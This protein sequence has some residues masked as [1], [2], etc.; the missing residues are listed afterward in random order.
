MRYRCG[1]NAG[2]GLLAAV[3]FAVWAVG[4]LSARELQPSE[5]PK[6]P[7][8][9]YPALFKAVALA[10]IFPAK[11]WADAVP[12]KPIEEIQ[13]AFEKADPED[14]AALKA[15]VAENFQLPAEQ[16]GVQVPEGLGLKA[17]IEA[18]W[19][20]L[21][22]KPESQVR[23]GS[24]IP[25]PHPYLV[26][27]G[28]FREIYYWDSYFTLLGVAGESLPLRK[29][30][31]DNFAYLIDRFGFIPNGNRTYYL[32]R[33]QPPFFFMMVGL[34]SPDDP[35]QAYMRYLPQLKREHD[36]WMSGAET[37]ESGDASGQVVRLKS[38]A[39]LNRYW[40][41]RQVPRDE[42][43]VIDVETGAKADRPLPELYRA[44]RAT[45]ESGW[46][47]SSRWFG[48]A[49][50]LAS[51]ETTAILPV[52]LNA[53]LYGLEQAIAAGCKAAGDP[54]CA[55]AFK[56][57]AEARKNA[58][59]DVLWD[60]DV[61]A[62][63]DYDWMRGGRRQIITPA[64]LYPL[65][66]SIA[67]QEQAEST[68]ALVEAQLLEKGG[69]LTTVNKTGQQWDAPN[70]WAPLHWIAVQGLGAYGQDELAQEIAGAW[71]TTVAYGYCTSAK[72]V[73]KYDVLER[74][75]GGGGEYPLQDGFGW[76]NGVTH[77]LL[78]E[79]SEFA[80]LAAVKPVAD[81]TLT[82]AEVARQ[83]SDAV[84]LDPVE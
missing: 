80:E 41:E 72:L 51:V 38:G 19:P 52:D 81:T 46:D 70:G 56:D 7:S 77:A 5:W 45:A 13:S 67:T 22:R 18:L 9:L 37:L 74:E 26:P 24:L 58:M 43:Y 48:A 28:R 61:G 60:A 57:R 20:L 66:F 33:S 50:N 47:F 44:L 63:L 29:D 3:V 16:T 27:G 69:L 59:E 65:F 64:V 75:P 34:L 35:A 82:K 14:A 71:L 25:L 2:R 8:E 78:A 31:V 84:A 54:D 23:G 1:W 68:A 32:S 10:K 83:C 11:D 36:Y 40:D 79:Y 53:L 4:A 39:V 49:D 12:R 6:P 21:T 62:F 30:M 76:T 42:S 17:H 55:N 15:F 73:E